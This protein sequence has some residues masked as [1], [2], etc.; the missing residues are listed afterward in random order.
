[1]RQ[2]K[3]SSGVRGA[4][5]PLDLDEDLY[6][7]VAIECDLLSPLQ[8]HRCILYRALIF[9]D[10]YWNCSRSLPY[11]RHFH[12]F[13]NCNVPPLHSINIWN[14]ALIPYT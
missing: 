9:N 1:M 4:S 5:G 10:Y 2:R 13:E 8:I 11:D 7:L 6:V 14:S 3:S 12:A